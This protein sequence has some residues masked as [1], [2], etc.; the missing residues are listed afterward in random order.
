ML[1]LVDRVA[2]VTG[3]SGALGAAAAR[4]LASLGAGVVVNYHR[5]AEPALSCVAAIREAGG[6][7]SAVQADVSTPAGA[8]A[9]IGHAT[10]EFGRLDILVNNAGITR[11][12]LAMRMSEADWDAVLDTNLKGAFL[13]SK[14]ALRPMIRQRWGRIVN[15]SSVAGLVGNAGQ[16]NYSAAKAGLI[17][18]TRALSREVASRAITVNAVAP[19]YIPS[20]IWQDVS[21]DAK[22]A[23]LAEVPLGRTGTPAEVAAAIAFFASEEAAYITG[24][25]LAIDG[26]MT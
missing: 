7:A 11:D 25:V 13:C 9:L 16:V 2:I 5:N 12:N 23:V 8:D 19:G 24:Q 15:V 21:E 6:R 4:Q 20:A 18:L 10:N 3:A 22:R 17:G 26:G 1:S 14:A